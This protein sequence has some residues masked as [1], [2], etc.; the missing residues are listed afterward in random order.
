M[1]D[2]SDHNLVELERAGLLVLDGVTAGA[3]LF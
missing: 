3:E 1:V 2:E